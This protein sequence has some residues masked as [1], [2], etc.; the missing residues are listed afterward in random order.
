MQ[1][2]KSLSIGTSHMSLGYVAISRS[3]HVMYCAAIQ[4]SHVA[5]SNSQPAKKSHN[6]RLSVTPN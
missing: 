6:A 1:H 2:V 4:Y 5:V 3:L